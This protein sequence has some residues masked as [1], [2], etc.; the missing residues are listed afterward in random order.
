MSLM[1]CV[2]GFDIR[3]DIKLFDFGLARELPTMKQDEG[4]GCFMMTLLAGTRRYMAPEVGL[5]KPYNLKA[6]VYSFGILLWHISS[7]LV[8]FDTFDVHDH[9]YAVWKCGVRPKLLKNWPCNVC[10]LMI[11]CWG[12]DWRD[13]PKFSEVC[14]V[15][16]EEIY[17]IEGNTTHFMNRSNE[18]K[19]RS[20]KSFGDK[21]QHGSS[22]SSKSD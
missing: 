15:L 7:L 18:L 11:S 20:E 8:P 13:R 12:A 21:S 1:L 9:E 3:G 4:S 17:R 5:G 19:C 2:V 16:R 6:D 22:Y 10:E 14:E